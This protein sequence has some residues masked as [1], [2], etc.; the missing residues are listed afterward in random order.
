MTIAEGTER[1][2]ICLPSKSDNWNPQQ[3]GKLADESAVSLLVRTNFSLEF[4]VGS[5]VPEQIREADSTV[6]A[7]IG[8][9]QN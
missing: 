7:E 1:F 3:D 5:V 6:G 9:V 8:F 2:G 4:V